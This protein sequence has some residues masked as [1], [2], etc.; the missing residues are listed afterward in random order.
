MRL[1]VLILITLL[2]MP[3]LAHHGS[4]GQFNHY[5]KVVVTGVVTDVKLVNPHSYVYFTATDSA[6]EIQEWRC[7]MR[8][9]SMLKRKGWTKAMFAVGTK[10]TVNGS[11]A[12]RE[13]F[14]CYMDTIT[15]AD[16]R[17]LSR[18]DVIEEQQG[19]LIVKADLAKG[20]PILHGNW[21]A[22]GR[23]EHL[24]EEDIAAASATAK[25]A[26]PADAPP[27][28]VR[29]PFSPTDTGIAAVGE[30][31][32]R[33]MNPRY[34]CKAT[35]IFHDWWFDEHVN[36]IEQTNEKITITYGFMGIVR[37]IHMNMD[38][39]PEN[40]TP[41]LAGH[42]I[43]RWEGS[44]LVVDT[45]G[46]KEGWLSATL[47]GVKHSN[48]MHTIEKFDLS[49][50]GEWLVMTYRIND[51]LYLNTPYIHQIIERR[52]NAPFDEW[53]CVEL[54]EERVKGF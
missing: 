13:R 39:H 36:K 26:W 35:N 52:T 19:G 25:A 22:P 51:P 20:T 5:D 33:E 10:I 1:S 15:F 47:H 42:S 27:R 40:I 48:Q 6:G 4:N 30:D 21:V 31:F 17:V 53:E 34:H 32:N 24:T 38:K 18:Y 23:R 8:G 44:T 29:P 45:V 7:E 14:G 46:F 50:N 37:T 16:G 41:S 54:T 2:S 43:G 11:Q 3:V 28:G 9:G 49:D 12:W